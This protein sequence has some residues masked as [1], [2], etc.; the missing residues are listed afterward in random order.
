MKVF[1]TPYARRSLRETIDFLSD[2]WNSE[3]IDSFLILIDERL[4]QVKAN[5]EMAPK[6]SSRPY[7]KLLIYK[8]VSLFY[9]NHK[10]YIKVLL[11]LD[12]RQ[13][14]DNLYNKLTAIENT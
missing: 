10:A 5:P 1:W 11:I 3:V 14:P 7:R 9:T 2:Q 4:A 12:N 8:H 13:A 6:L